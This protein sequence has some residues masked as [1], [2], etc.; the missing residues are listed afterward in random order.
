MSRA[1]DLFLER[2]SQRAVRDRMIYR[3][4]IRGGSSNGMGNAE[5]TIRFSLKSDL[6]FN[7]NQQMFNPNQVINSLVV[8]IFSFW[9]PSMHFG[10][11]P[12]GEQ[13]RR[14]L[15]WKSIE[16]NSKS[17]MTTGNSVHSPTSTAPK[18][19]LDDTGIDA[20]LADHCFVK[21]VR[22][23]FMCPTCICFP[24]SSFHEVVTL[25]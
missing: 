12:D 15:C 13:R 4:F 20:Y 18:A 19:S 16:H 6:S 14:K 21:Q 23:C 9:Q 3:V 25:C 7:N 10:Y 24:F 5:S 17:P 22:L 8:F 11:F 1:S 2:L